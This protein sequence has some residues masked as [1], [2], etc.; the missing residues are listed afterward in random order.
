M[1]SVFFSEKLAYQ[2]S[3]E[4][5][6]NFYDNYKI[7]SINYKKSNL[8]INLSHE[9]DTNKHFI[10]SFK[11]ADNLSIDVS[12]FSDLGTRTMNIDSISF[13]A[14]SDFKPNLFTQVYT[15]ERMEGNE[16][17]VFSTQIFE[18]LKSDIIYFFINTC[19]GVTIEFSAKS[20][21]CWQDFK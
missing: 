13:L 16:G 14:E 20:F 7:E 19:N 10:F 12:N 17:I 1:Q 3:S 11:E 5:F 15:Y 21:T 2:S 9:T 18:K 8:A 4:P 6:L